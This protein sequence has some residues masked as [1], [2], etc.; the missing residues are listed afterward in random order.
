MGKPII[1]GRKTYES[2]GRP[3]PGR[4]NIVITRNR[5]WCADGVIVVNS[6]SQAYDEIECDAEAFVIGGAEIYSSALPLVDKIYL[7]RINLNVDGD[8]F[9]PLIPIADWR[10]VSKTDGDLS[11]PLP[12]QFLIYERIKRK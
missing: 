11:A 9:L 4:K 3:L 7:T 2:I 1:M 6:L 10:L 12:H 8:A 5:D